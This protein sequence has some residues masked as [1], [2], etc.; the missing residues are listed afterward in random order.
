MNFRLLVMSFLCAFFFSLSYAQ[1]KDDTWRVEATSME[2]YTGAP[3]ANGRIGILPWK[4]PFSVEHVILNHVFDV[5]DEH[6]V[7]R[8]LM[9][10]NPFMLKMRVD[11]KEVSENNISHWKQTIDMR[12]SSHTT[13]FTVDGKAEVSYTIRALYNLPY[14]GLISVDIHALNPVSIEVDNQADVPAGYIDVNKTFKSLDAGGKRMNILEVNASSGKRMQK[15]A[16]SSLFIYPEDRF[17][18]TNEGQT[19]TSI[20]TKM[21]AGEKLSFSL[22]GSICST[23]DFVD[24]ASESERQV[25]YVAHEGV[26]EVIAAHNRFW[27]NLWQGDIEIEGDD[28]AQKT[29]RFAL[30]NLYSYCR[31][32]SDLSI[33]PMGLSSQGYNGHIFWDSEIWMFPPMLFLNQGIAQSMI[34]YRTNRLAAAEKR[35]D[36]YG[37][38]G[39]MFPWESDDW[40]RRIHSHFF[41]YGTV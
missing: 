26:G 28:E 7:T 29:V 27:D 9:G 5:D 32:G 20:S 21:T 39:A 3:V 15:V 10:I 4:E 18:L 19:K 17:S 23:R 40:G 11:G 37:Y 14:S 31:A 13:S 24:P 33:S 22:V 38:K 34:N 1:Q 41:Y 30:Y 12:H 35:A 8:V 36:N 16:S 25:I 2:N 6:G